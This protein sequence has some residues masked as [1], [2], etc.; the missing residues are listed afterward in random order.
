MMERDEDTFYMLKEMAEDPHLSS[1][2]YNDEL[3][4]LDYYANL[5]VLSNEEVSLL[6]SLWHE[7]YITCQ[8]EK[9]ASQWMVVQIFIL[10]AVA[11]YIAWLSGGIA[12]TLISIVGVIAVI[13]M[14]EDKRIEQ[15]KRNL[16]DAKQVYHRL[17]ELKKSRQVTTDEE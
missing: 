7:K 10:V 12:G 6:V 17:G 5:S 2:N 4:G 11:S 16:R 3:I 8:K 14:I 13:A 9:L 15:A 1:R